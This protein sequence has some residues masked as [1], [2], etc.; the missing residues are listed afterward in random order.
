MLQSD[1]EIP[2]KLMV[3]G[4]VLC[5]MSIAILVSGAIRGEDSMISSGLLFLMAGLAL[6][7]NPGQSGWVFRTVMVLLAAT[8]VVWVLLT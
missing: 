5:A 4:W 6:A 8:T 3:S 1:E 7:K 2:D